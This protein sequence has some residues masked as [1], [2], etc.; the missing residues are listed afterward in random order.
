MS[1]ETVEKL[2]QAIFDVEYDD[3]RRPR[4]DVEPQWKLYEKHAIA[5]LEALSEPT[6]EMVSAGNAEIPDNVGFANDASGVY[7]A[8]IKA[9][10]KE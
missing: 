6:P 7:R 8:M 1:D 9:A 2:A 5:V 4:P 10:R 3:L